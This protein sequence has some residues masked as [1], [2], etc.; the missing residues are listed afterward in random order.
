M[1]YDM[2]NLGQKIG[3]IV[4]LFLALQIHFSNKQKARETYE[5]NFQSEELESQ[6]S[7]GGFSGDHESIES[8]DFAFNEIVAEKRNVAPIIQ[9][10]SSVP[11]FAYPGFT[12]PPNHRFIF[13]NKLPK[14][15]SSTMK[16]LLKLLGKRNNFKLDHQ[17]FCIHPDDC[18]ES[19]RDDGPNGRKDFYNY[20]KKMMQKMKNQKY[21]LLKHH[22]WFNFTEFGLPKPTYI[23]VAR[24]PV[25]RFASKYYF[26]RY[27]WSMGEAGSRTNEKGGFKGNE[28][29]L[30]RSLDDCV[31]LQVPECTDALQVMVKYFCGTSAECNEHNEQGKTQWDKV[32]ISAEIAKKNILREFYF[33]GLLEKFDETLELFENVLPGYFAGAREAMK[34]PLIGKKRE[35]SKSKANAGYSNETIAALQNGILK[36]EVDIY[37]LIEKLFYERL[38]FIR[39]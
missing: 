17:R 18:Y 6:N 10:S 38:A 4:L 37:S 3:T 35:Q 24:D 20:I 5:A 16:N 1:K 12:E 29:D 2:R 14:C 30:N 27:G 19:Y 7:E 21:V 13:H 39:K 22:H 26:Q 34:D 8:L 25:T 36:Y 11:G 33:I 15:G 31:R 23:N 28:E 32:A 9:A